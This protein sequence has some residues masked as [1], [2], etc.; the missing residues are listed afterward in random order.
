MMVLLLGW[1]LTIVVPDREHLTVSEVS[2]LFRCHE[3]T[4]RRW[5]LL[6]IG[7]TYVETAAG[8]VLYP[9]RDLEQY[10]AERTRTPREIGRY[11]TE[12]KRAAQR[13]VAS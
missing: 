10:V 4:L 2:R 11:L 7:P 9:R 5:R 12:R 13:E 3:S 8:R 1:A 6:G